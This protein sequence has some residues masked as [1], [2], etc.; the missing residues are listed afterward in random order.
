MALTEDGVVEIRPRRPSS[1]VTVRCPA[2]A[3][4][5]IGTAS[6]SVELRGRSARSASR[7][8]AARS[9]WPRWPKPTCAPIRLGRGRRLPDQAAGS[10]PRA[11]RSPSATPGAP[12]CRPCPA[13][14][15]HEGDRGGVGADGER[16]G[17]DQVR[18]S[19][20]G[21]RPE[22][23]GGITVHLPAGTA[24]RSRWRAWRWKGGLRAGRRRGRRRDD[25]E[26][27]GRGHGP[28]MPATARPPVVQGAIVFTDLVGLH[29]VHGAVRRRGRARPPRRAGPA[30]VARRSPRTRVV[31]ELGD[32]LLLFFPMRWPPSAP[33][34]RCR[35]AST[36][37][38]GHRPA[39]VDAHRAP[40]RAGPP[41]GRRPR[42]PRRQ[43]RGPHR[44]PGR[45][46]RGAGLGRRPAP[47]S[48]TVP[49][50]ASMSWVPW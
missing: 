1:A 18:R 39:A 43:R 10:R 49:R 13:R 9:G 29:G 4:L 5:V 25:G 6:G 30:G 15:G 42:R 33:G 3:V 26:R 37:S 28:L 27:V 19:E 36:P 14:C 41:P 20:A 12:R 2:G 47:R 24:R 7:R 21:A 22:R 44:R 31:K 11:A 32:G 45:A 23:L 34:S 48:T 46:G 38:R 8:P 16:R 17:D 35:R 50:S 40:R